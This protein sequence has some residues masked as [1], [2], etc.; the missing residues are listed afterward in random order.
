MARGIA[1]RV[2]TREEMAA[3]LNALPFVRWDVYDLEQQPLADGGKVPDEIPTRSKCCGDCAYRNGSPERTEDGEQEVDVLAL[4]LRPPAEFWC[5]QGVRRAIAY[6][7]PDGRETPAGVGD[8]QPP[9]GPPDRP[10][11]WKADG[12]IGERCAGWAAHR[13]ARA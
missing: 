9:Q 10:V 5:H 13:G 6:R 4:A 2:V 12:T 7:H 11:V 1:E 8:Y 3:F